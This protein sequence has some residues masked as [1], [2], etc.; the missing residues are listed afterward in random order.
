MKNVMLASILNDSFYFF[1][2]N[3]ISLEK[4]NVDAKF[5]EYLWHSY[6][7]KILFFVCN[8]CHIEKTELK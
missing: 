5:Y 6:H 1:I 8:F 3:Y 4:I 2:L 7:A